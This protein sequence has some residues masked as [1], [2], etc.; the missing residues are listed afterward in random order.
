MIP[1][2]V[3]A[4]VIDKARNASR[5]VQAGAQTIPMPAPRWKY[6]R[7]TSSQYQHEMCG[8]QR[9]PRTCPVVL[10]ACTD[11]RRGAEY[12]FGIYATCARKNAVGG[13]GPFT[14]RAAHGAIR[15][16]ILNE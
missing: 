14:A 2:P 10:S 16:M 15:K 3:A 4:Q 12:V 6:P 13:P 9:Q 5:V 8:R 1:V 11:R 7:L